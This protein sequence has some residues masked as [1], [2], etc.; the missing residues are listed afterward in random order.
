[1]TPGFDKSLY[2][3][4]FDHRGSFQIKMFGWEGELSA[5]QT[6]EICRKQV[7]Y[8]GLK[9]R[10]VIAESLSGFPARVG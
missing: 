1:M 3:L 6:A 5:H 7:I 4:P 10:A 8:E 9:A 2:I